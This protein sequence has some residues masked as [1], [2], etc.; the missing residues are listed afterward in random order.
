MICRVFDFIL[1]T[2]PLAPI[3]LT[4]AIILSQRAS[5]SQCESM[6][7]L[8]EYFSEALGGV[9]MEEMCRSAFCL[10]Q[11]NEPQRLLES[12]KIRFISE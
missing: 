5:V 10:M 6:P 1:G 7:E 12:S 11:R 9:D 3:Y 4:T 2:H 8:H